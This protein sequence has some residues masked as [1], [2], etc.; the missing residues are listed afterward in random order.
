MKYK[1]YRKSKPPCVV[2]IMPDRRTGKYCFV[3][4]TSLHVCRCRF[5]TVEEAIADLDKRED[6]VEYVELV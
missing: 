3:N 2:C 5:D 4:L 6:V 1:V